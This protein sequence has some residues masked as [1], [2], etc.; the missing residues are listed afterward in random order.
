LDALKQAPGRKKKDGSGRA[1]ALIAER[2]SVSQTTV[3]QAKS[4]LKHAGPDLIQAVRNGEISVKSAY[5][6]L[7]RE[8][9][10]REPVPENHITPFPRTG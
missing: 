4:L 2:F 10:P 5:R 8:L 9:V 3:Y 7:R 1:A 6:K